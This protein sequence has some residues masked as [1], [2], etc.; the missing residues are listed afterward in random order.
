MR[1]EVGDDENGGGG[2]AVVLVLVLFAAGSHGRH[3]PWASRWMGRVEVD[4]L[5]D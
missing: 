3:G 4:G 5:L 2:S 1:D